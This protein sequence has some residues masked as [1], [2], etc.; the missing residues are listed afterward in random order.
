MSGIL[1]FHIIAIP[2]V[3][4]LGRMSNRIAFVR[5]KAENRSTVPDFLRGKE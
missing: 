2:V 5:V 1:L 3:F 4:M